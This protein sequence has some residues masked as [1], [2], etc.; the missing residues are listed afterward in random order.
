M[1]SYAPFIAK[2]KA[3]IPSAGRPR[4]AALAYAQV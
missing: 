4:S 2:S 1:G 3:V